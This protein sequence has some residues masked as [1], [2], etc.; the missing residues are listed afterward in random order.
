MN[1]CSMKPFGTSTRIALLTSGSLP[2][3]EA[4]LGACGASG[5]RVSDDCDGPRR[6]GAD[7]ARAEVQHED[8]MG[9]HATKPRLAGRR[10]A[11]SRCHGPSGLVRPCRTFRVIP[12]PKACPREMTCSCARRIAARAAR[13]NSR[14]EACPQRGIRI[15]Q[16]GWRIPEPLT[17]RTRVTSMYLR[18]RSY[19]PGGTSIAS[20]GASRAG[21]L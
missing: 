13:S 15:R 6:I 18:S 14:N 17:G 19:K 12:Q 11:G 9:A 5:K 20:E 3:N 16:N 10:V 21:R 8:A 2:G 4:Q 1:T 7:L